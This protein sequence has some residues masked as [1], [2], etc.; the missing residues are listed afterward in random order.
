MPFRCIK[1]NSSW[2]PIEIISWWKACNLVYFDEHK[3]ADVLWSYP[4]EHKLR[5]QYEAWSYPA[6]IVLKQ[7]SKRKSK[8]V[9]SPGLKAILVRDLYTCQYCGSSL[10]N[11]TGTRDH[12]I[13]E[14]KGGPG[15]W[16]N[17]VAACKH[18]QAKKADK[19]CKDVNM[20]PKRKPEEPHFSD[21]FLNAIKI[22]SSTERMCWKKGFKHLG[23]T[24]LS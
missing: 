15:T 20:F 2:E 22:S 10:T 19:F 18:C 11:S 13:P 7:Y 21:R 14:S 23:L 12:V 3:K 5:A 4:E 6:I 24:Y 8:K 16:E 9:V 17:L 1:L